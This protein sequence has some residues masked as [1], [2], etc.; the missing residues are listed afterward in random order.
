L[1]IN[2]IAAGGLAKT[3]REK[4]EN[5]H[6]RGE[7]NGARLG[8]IVKKDLVSGL[9]VIILIF[10]FAYGISAMRVPVPM[11]PTHAFN[12]DERT[13]PIA[14]AGT[15]GPPVGRVIMRVNGEPITESE[16][17]AS[18][19][20]LPPEMQQQ[21]SSEQ[22]KQAFAEQLVRMKLLEQEAR[23][24]HLENDPRVAAQLAANRT[25]VLASAAAQKL[26]ATASPAEVQKFYND[27][28]GQ[29]Q[30]ADLYHI[31]IAYQGGMIPPKN[32]GAPPDERTAV[33]KA[34]QIYQQL[35]EGAKFEDM[36][37]QYSDDTASAARG[38][39][40]GQVAPGML[41][42]ELEARILNMREGEIS[43]AIP[44]RYGVHIFKMGARHT[45]P[46]SDV[47]ERIAARVKQEET[48]RRVED[49]RK[50]AKVDFDPKFFPDAKNWPS[51]A[52][53]PGPGQGRP[54][55]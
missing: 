8:A 9:I 35:K 5:F 45:R 4:R 16:F 2:A 23:K 47:Q 43:T 48:M 30:T 14:P 10:A 20:S 17:A 44:S 1:A 18:F 50:A 26:V 3:S 53:K 24:Q 36:A 25:D 54:P 28:K 42:Q 12:L 49:M 15:P 6:K 7:Y 27:N 19:A 29:M 11:Q 31:V 34:L 41:P 38:G 13:A 22:G 40:L 39:F 37:K 46:L 51:G 33:N 55:A 32:G 52:P 21:F